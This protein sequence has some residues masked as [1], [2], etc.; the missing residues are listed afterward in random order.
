MPAKRKFPIS[1]GSDSFLP[2]K[3]FFPRQGEILF[4]SFIFYLYGI[5]IVPLAYRHKLN[6]SSPEAF[7]EDISKRFAANVVMEEE[8]KNYHRT[9]ILRLNRDNANQEISIRTNHPSEDYRFL[10]E[11]CSKDDSI[12]FQVFPCH[13]D[14]YMMDSPF[15]WR[16][17]EYCIWSNDEASCL[18]ELMEYRK[19]I[20]KLCDV[21][22]C[23][24][25]LYIPDQGCTE[26]IWDKAS[27]GVDY[28][29]LFE[30]IRQRKYCEDSEDRTHLEKSM[31]LDLPCFLSKP[32]HCD[33]W[34]D[35]YLDVIMDDFRDLK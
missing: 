25:C 6:I 32:M 12:S 28:E 16:G 7:A 3:E 19:S 33:S 4:K 22:G 18:E 13:I 23:T 30:Y 26:Y 2:R 21:C 11:V 24:K 1:A 17:F 8:D 14:M 9:E 34:P 29:S 15:R 27:S 20:K 10:Y 5:D 31:V 35:V